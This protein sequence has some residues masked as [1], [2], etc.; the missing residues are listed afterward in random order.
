MESV[1]STMSKLKV[2]MGKSAQKRI[3]KDIAEY[4]LNPMSYATFVS[5]EE[6]MYKG[7]ISILIQ[8]GMYE[9]VMMHLEITFPADYPHEAPSVHIANGFPFTSKFHERKST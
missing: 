5:D 7:H 1:T 8:E 6:N 9:G 4:N 3:M 2:N